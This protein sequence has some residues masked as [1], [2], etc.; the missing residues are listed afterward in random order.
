MT[1]EFLSSIV[2]HHRFSYAAERDLHVGLQQ[3]FEDSG[4]FVESEVR[5]GPR[6]RLDLVVEDFIVEVKIK[7]NVAALER[8]IM[9]YSKLDYRGVLVVTS[10]RAHLGLV[11][12]ESMPCEV[13]VINQ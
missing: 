13:V 11:K 6:N 9:R 10:L 3:V 4:L 2:R 8:Q 1:L 5:C 7:G 12:P